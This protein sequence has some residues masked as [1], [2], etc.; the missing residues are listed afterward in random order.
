M[1]LNGWDSAQLCLAAYLHASLCLVHFSGQAPA[2]LLCHI[3][4]SVSPFMSLSCCF[5]MSLTRCV[6]FC[7]CFFV[8]FPL[9]ASPLHLT[10]SL[11]WL[12]LSLLWMACIS[13]SAFSPCAAPFLS[14]FVPVGIVC[15]WV[16]VSFFCSHLCVHHWVV[17]SLCPL[18]S[19]CFSV[20]HACGRVGRQEKFPWYT[21]SLRPSLT[22][23]RLKEII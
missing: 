20:Q 13:R 21:P 10:V 1:A 5:W 11:Q 22:V 2:F 7:L 9:W 14:L 4:F 19:V 6:P 16:C 15:L 17:I 18:F 8:H 12:S 23:K 3:Y